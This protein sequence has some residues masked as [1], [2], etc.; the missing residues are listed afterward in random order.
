MKCVVDQIEA[1]FTQ[2]EPLGLP[3]AI[4]RLACRLSMKTVPMEPHS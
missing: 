4:S 2:E 3:V 1:R